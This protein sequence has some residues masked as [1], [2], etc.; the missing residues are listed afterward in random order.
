MPTIE[1]ASIG[2]TQP[3]D[4][5]S[6]SSFSCLLENKLLSHRSLFQTVFDG[7]SGIMVHL[8]NKQRETTKSGFWFAADLIDWNESGHDP[9]HEESTTLIFLPDALLD[10]RDLMQRLLA[11]SP[12]RLITFSTD[13]QFGGISHENGAISLSQFF[14]LHA[15][16]KLHF[17]HLWHVHPD[18]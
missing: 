12:Q 9:Q 18:S 2:C 8:A 7:L 11:A 13:Y 3:P 17:N 10:I 15:T 4:L 1:L 6:Y 14:N 16:R 5:P